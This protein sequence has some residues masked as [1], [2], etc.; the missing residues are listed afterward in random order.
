MAEA[1]KV[2]RYM[3]RIAAAP[4]REQLAATLTVAFAIF[5][6][7]TIYGASLAGSMAPV[8][9][10]L[11][12]AL[13]FSGAAQFTTAGLLATGA[14]T[15]TVLATV[16]VLN[17]RHLLLGA[18]LR[19]RFDAPAPARAAMAFFLIDETVGLSLA[20]REQVRRTYLIAG[21]ASYLAWVGGTAVGVLGGAAVGDERLA[22][23]VFPVLFVGLAAAA[24]RNRTDALRA[25]MAVAATLVL[26]F[27]LPGVAGLAPIVV[28]PALAW[29]GT[30]R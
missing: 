24:V 8:R 4:P 11:T 2:R 21:V 9:A 28:A 23:A 25:V 15:A 13:V 1:V 14:G 17:L 10:T 16:A 29:L 3:G 6:F 20:A 12:S 19:Q 7:G 18:V 5:V 30:R 27:T 26:A 22:E